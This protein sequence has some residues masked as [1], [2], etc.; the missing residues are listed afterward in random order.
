MRVG[1]GP[2]PRAL[3]H[4][5]PSASPAALG[6][7]DVRIVDTDYS[8]FAVVYIYKELEGALSTMVQLYSEARSRPP[9][10]LDTV[11]PI[12]PLPSLS[13]L[14]SPL[15]TCPHLLSCPTSSHTPK[16][17]PGKD[18]VGVGVVGPHNAWDGWGLT[19]GVLEGQAHRLKLTI[20]SGFPEGGAPPFL[21]PSHCLRS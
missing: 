15:Q 18:Q 12:P 4:G 9:S 17:G 16:S 2:G 11:H 6:Y 7:L 3:L 8:S 10:P 13:P 5:C 14:V 1:S 20:L 21:S 19:G